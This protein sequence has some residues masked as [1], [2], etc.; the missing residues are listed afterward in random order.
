MRERFMAAFR[1]VAQGASGFARVDLIAGARL[2]VGS[3]G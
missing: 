3:V 1:A 2:D